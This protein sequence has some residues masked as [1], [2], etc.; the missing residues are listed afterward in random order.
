MQNQM[1]LSG[2]IL[3]GG[4]S[5]RM[6]QD[7]GLMLFRGKQMVQYSIE[8]LN[9]FTSQILI[10]SNNQEYNQFGFPVVSDIYKECGPIGGL[11]AAVLPWHEKG[12]EP[13]FGVYNK[14]MSS[15]FEQK[16]NEKEFKLQKVLKEKN[17]NYFETSELIKQIPGLFSNINF[18]EDLSI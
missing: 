17:I 15:F 13:L 2:I 16:I 4:K 14:R 5:S 11:H 7:K 3:A 1:E 10:S 18:P 6:G 8:L 12:F 9:L